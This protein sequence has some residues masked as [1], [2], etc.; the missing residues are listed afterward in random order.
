MVAT[1]PRLVVIGAPEG[2]RMA[3]AARLADHYGIPR[4]PA[5]DVLVKRQPLPTGGFVIDGAARLLDRVAG[6]GGPLPASALDLVV[7]LRDGDPADSDGAW[8]VIRFYEARGVLVGFRPQTPDGDII[9]AIDAALRGRTAADP[10]RW[11]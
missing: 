10:P 6:I 3:R 5:L 7:H 2:M 9:V 4:L 1:A 11:P 8:R